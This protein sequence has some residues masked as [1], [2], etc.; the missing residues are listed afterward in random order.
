MTRHLEQQEDPLLAA[1]RRM[2]DEAL[3]FRAKFDLF[4][5][6]LNRVIDTMD[7]GTEGSHG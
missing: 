4:I 7:E 3:A 6:K 2:H 1:S 5:D